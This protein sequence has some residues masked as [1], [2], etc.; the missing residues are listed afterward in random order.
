[1][2]DLTKI[3]EMIIGLAVAIVTGLLIPLLRQ[4]M[5]AGQQEKL[6]TVIEVAIRSAEQLYG[7]GMGREKLK[8]ALD[9]IE[10]KGYTVDLQQVEA[11]VQALLNADRPTKVIADTE[12]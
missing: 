9:Y 10:S 12:E 3:V 1:M 5:T 8:A 11:A 4:R 7:A 6:D 2:I